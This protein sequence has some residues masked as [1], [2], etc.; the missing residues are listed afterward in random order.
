MMMKKFL[1]L[2]LAFT[3]FFAVTACSANTGKETTADT[4]TTESTT[5]PD[6]LPEP[7][8]EAGENKI[9]TQK[10]GSYISVVY[11][12][13]YCS[14]AAK[15]KKG[16]G[17]KEEV[18]L[19]IKMFSSYTFDG[20][21]Q[22]SALPNENAA[23]YVSDAAGKRTAKKLAELVGG[24]L[25]LSKETVYTFT[26]S[27]DITVY[28]NYSVSVIY[29][30][31]GGTVKGGGES[32]TQKYSVVMYKCPNTLPDKDYFVRDGYTL[33]EYN[34]KADGSGTAVGLGSRIATGGESSIELYCIWKKQSPSTDF[35]Y[36]SD[37]GKIS[38]SKYTGKDK[39]IAIPE[40][41]DG[42]SV[43]KIEKGAFAGSDIEYV[44]IPKTVTK[45]EDGAFSG[46]G[47][48]ETL[49]IFD[50]LTNVTDESFES[51]G[52]L[53]NLRINAALDHYAAVTDGNNKIDRVIWAKT[54]G[55]K[56]IVIVGG[57]GSI[58][59]FDSAAIAEKYGNEYVIINLGTNANISA[60]IYFEYLSSVLD[61]DDI[62]LW[63]PEAGEYV[64][65]YTAMHIRAWEFQSG[66]YD[67]FRSVD[68]SKYTKVFSSFATYA[69]AHKTSE[70]PFDAFMLSSSDYKIPYYNEYGDAIEPRSHQEK[71]YDGEYSYSFERCHS[72]FEKGA[73]DYM[74]SVIEKM[75]SR[76]VK[77][78]L[79][80]AAM[81][82]DAEKSFDTFMDKFT[83]AV[84][85]KYKGTEVISDYHNILM[86]DRY[87]SDSAWHM[88]L[89]G[90]AKRT[91]T[92]ISDLNKKLGK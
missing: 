54:T 38:I 29:N 12:P 20:W 34:T 86:D 27:E 19:Q 16:V 7:S 80:Y 17:S 52:K 74:A 25:L 57:S 1:C 89:E 82:K 90:A 24:T 42:K 83:A 10:I 4:K 78:W 30:A 66:H 35:E 87:M 58:N 60:T 22:I 6:V 53:K 3:V 71:S 31:N 67:I 36:T 13:A 33:V 76:G 18:T 68:I 88:T 61:K 69:R 28:A 92:V 77:V 41:I 91:E 9:I 72:G 84:K 55:K 14:V 26:A 2:L 56:L 79:I 46:C 73:Y 23:V 37:D 21:S 51:C 85:E 63:A 65:G 50:T 8:D 81:D 62:I 49:V 64:L 45:I 15:I 39:S 75:T 5:N 70:E 48:L 59:G 40:V 44:V 47:S 43:Y 11:N 32:Y